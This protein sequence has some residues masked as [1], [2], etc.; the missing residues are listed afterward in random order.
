MLFLFFFVI[1]INLNDGDTICTLT[2]EL[3][4]M[5]KDDQSILATTHLHTFTYFQPRF[6]TIYEQ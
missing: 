5:D 2:G 1:V 6:Y 3:T 4:K